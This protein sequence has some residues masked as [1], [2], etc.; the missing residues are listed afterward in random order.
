MSMAMA[1]IWAEKVQMPPASFDG[2]VHSTQS[3]TLRTLKMF[4]W[5]LLQSQFQALR[6]S[7]KTALAH[8][9]LPAQTQRCGKKFFR[10]Q[11]AVW[12]DQGSGWPQTLR[13]PGAAAFSFWRA[14]PNPESM[15]CTMEGSKQA[16]WSISFRK[17]FNWLSMGVRKTNCRGR[18]ARSGMM[19]ASLPQLANALTI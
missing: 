5:H 4:P 11:T 17:S 8:S 15:R 10:C 6:F 13:R 1:W 9:P 12:A 16:I 7:L 18:L 19:A 3:F 2:V 14:D